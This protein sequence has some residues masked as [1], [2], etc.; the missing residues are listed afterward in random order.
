MYNQVI[1]GIFQVPKHDPNSLTILFP[2]LYEPTDSY[3]P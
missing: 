3:H 2:M 1:E